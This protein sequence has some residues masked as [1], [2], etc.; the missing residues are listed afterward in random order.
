MDQVID[1]NLMW[2]FRRT[3]RRRLK[4]SGH[5]GRIIISVL[6]VGERIYDAGLAP[7]SALRR[8][9]IFTQGC[10]AKSVL[11]VGITHNIHRARSIQI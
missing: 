11:A 4:Q 3:P 6:V 2:P 8:V 9:K 10:R 1:L 5:G 7:Y